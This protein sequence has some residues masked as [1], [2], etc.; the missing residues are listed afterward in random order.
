MARIGN[1]LRLNKACCNALIL[2]WI[3]QQRILRKLLMRWVNTNVTLHIFTTSI[4]TS[5]TCK[6]L[7]KL[8][9][10]CLSL[11]K[12]KASRLEILVCLDIF[13]RIRHVI[14][15]YWCFWHIVWRFSG[16]K[17][18]RVFF[19][20]HGCFLGHFKHVSF[21]VYLDNLRLLVCFR[22]FCFFFWRLIE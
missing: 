14:G 10:S 13:C 19:S 15:Q 3:T 12:Q 16:W 2:V 7:S 20:V 11:F 17:D 22:C 9:H 1:Y 5:V 18:K 6:Q 4:H 21:Q 8:S